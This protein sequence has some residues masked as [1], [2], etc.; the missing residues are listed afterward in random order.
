MISWLY[1]NG[2][3]TSNVFLEVT[4]FKIVEGLHAFA[5]SDMHR[6]V[7]DWWNKIVKTFLN[8]SIYNELYHHSK[9]FYY[10]KAR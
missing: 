10:F 6:K 3:E 2:C 5:H 7:W 4:Y 9:V 8:L 1:T